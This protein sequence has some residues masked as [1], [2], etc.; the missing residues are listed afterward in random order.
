VHGDNLDELALLAGAGMTLE[1]VLSAT[2][3][4]AGE[5]ITPTG[6]VGRLAPS[7]LADVVVL[8]TQLHSVDQLAT[9]R[10]MI[11]QVWKDGRNQFPE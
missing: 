8:N 6:S 9:L 10:T 7:Y 1:Q 11:S 4:V 5:L 3:A 2:T